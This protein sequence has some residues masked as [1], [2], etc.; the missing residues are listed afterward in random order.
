MKRNRKKISIPNQYGDKAVFRPDEIACICNI[1]KSMVYRLI[2][3][4]EL[5]ATIMRPKR[6]PRRALID[7]LEKSYPGWTVE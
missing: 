5:E 6:V 7:F 1:S 4:R 2:R 3:E